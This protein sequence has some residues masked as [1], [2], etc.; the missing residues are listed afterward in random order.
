MSDFGVYTGEQFIKLKLPPRKWL[1]EGLIRERDSIILVGN[2]KSGK[3]LFVFQLICSLTSQHPFI[4]R[5]EVQKPC[6][7][8]YVQIEGELTDSQDRFKRMT[9]ALDMD[10]Y[11]LQLLFLPPQELEKHGKMV[12]LAD[13]I[14]EHKPDIIIIDPVYFAFTGGLSDDLAVRQFIGNLRVLKDRLKCA[15]ILVHHTHKVKFDNKGNVVMEGDD[16][17]FGSKFLK[18]WPDHLIMFSYDQRKEI[19]TVSCSTQR[20]GD[21]IKQCN[22]RLIQ[23]KPLYFEETE[24]ALSKS[25]LIMNILMQTKQEMT[26]DELCRALDIGRNSFYTSVKEPLRDGVIH[27]TDSRPVRYSYNNSGLGKQP[28]S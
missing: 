6:R 23:P 15:L 24:K 11:N 19:R 9:E 10:W 16:A 1:V 14:Q 3:S 2:E 13:Q 12:G 22:L 5:W 18:A 28:E 7:V 17:I 25:A 26:A 21:I 4:D 8:S 27:K 20:S